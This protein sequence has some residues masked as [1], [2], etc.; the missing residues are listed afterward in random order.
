MNYHIYDNNANKEILFTEKTCESQIIKSCELL[1]NVALFVNNC[2]MPNIR[3]FKIDM[4]K[5]VDKLN[6]VKNKMLE[7]EY[8]FYSLL[9]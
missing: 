6:D 4:N 2:N 3:N 5:F 9:R 1:R 7:Y 8:K